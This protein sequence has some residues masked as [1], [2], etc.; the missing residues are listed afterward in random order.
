MKTYLVVRAR[1]EDRD[2]KKG[3]DSIIRLDYMGA[4]EFEWGAVPESLEAIRASIANYTYMDYPMH[5]KII[6]VFCKADVR[7][8]VI[9]MLN[10][11]AD[12]NM[13]TKC[14]TDFDN[15]LTPSKHELEWQAKSPL[16]TNFW[17]DIDNHVMFW[18]K[19]NEFEV[20][21]KSIIGVKPN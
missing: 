10:E 4:S 11:L 16:K 18:V 17:W 6:T 2:Y 9:A 20:K 15:L 1:I 13:H 8:E 14:Y 12:G 21:F 5:G 7:T 3:I 19:N